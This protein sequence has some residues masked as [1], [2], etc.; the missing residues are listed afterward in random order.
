MPSQMI[1]ERE[2]NNEMKNNRINKD[3]LAKFHKNEDQLLLDAFACIDKS[4][5]AINMDKIFNQT[6]DLD[7]AQIMDDHQL[8]PTFIKSPKS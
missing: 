2:T 7:L 5:N 6:M 4:K 1:N 8:S 3:E